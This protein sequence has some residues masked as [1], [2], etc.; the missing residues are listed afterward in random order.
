MKKLQYVVKRGSAVGTVLRP[1]RHADGTYVVSMTRFERDYIRVASEDDLAEW[2]DRGYRV[3]MSNP[4]V[5]SH[6]SPSLIAP[7]SIE[8]A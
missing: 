2:V 7:A 5:A 6:R 4:D 1:H 8:H 3:R